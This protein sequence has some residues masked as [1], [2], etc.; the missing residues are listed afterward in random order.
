MPDT[1]LAANPT[2]PLA[3]AV[4]RFDPDV[5]LVPVARVTFSDADGIQMIQKLAV[6]DDLNLLMLIEQKY[7]V[8]MSFPFPPV[9]SGP[10]S[11]IPPDTGSTHCQLQ[12]RSWPIWRGT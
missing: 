6:E 2:S 4:V 3:Q 9:S 11:L 1:A 8:M 10:S 5:A 12:R 7:C